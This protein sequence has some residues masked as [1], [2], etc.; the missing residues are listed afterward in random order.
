METTTKDA[1]QM[2]ALVGAMTEEVADLRKQMVIEQ[3]VAESHCRIYRGSH[4]GKDLVLVQSGMGKEMAERAIR[5]TLERFSIATVVSFGYSGA[6]TQV[7]RAGDVIV[8]RKLYGHNDAVPQ[9]G[10]SLSACH[11]DAALA[12]A[13][14]EAFEGAQLKWMEADS[15]TWPRLVRDPHAKTELGS[16]FSAQAVDMESYWIARI[17]DERGIPFLSIRAISDTASDPLPPFDTLVRSDGR[18]RARRAALYFLPRPWQLTTLFR[19]YR[20]ARCARESLKVA[21]DCF[22]GRL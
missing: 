13:A 14:A 18:L 10:T 17:A 3:T 21:V 12:L 16:I 1:T 11:S 6:L 15:I 8:C 7:L 19:F 22:L 9:A 2:L 20:Q 4:Q 5:L